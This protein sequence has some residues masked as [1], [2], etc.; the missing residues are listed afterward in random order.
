[1]MFLWI[2]RP[3]LDDAIVER[4]TTECLPP[5]RL[6]EPCSRSKSYS[7][8]S[9]IAHAQ[10]T[11]QDWPKRTRCRSELPPG[12]HRIGAYNLSRQARSG[13]WKIGRK[14]QFAP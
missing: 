5:V 12:V 4:K 1:M 10:V 11:W 8:S 9:A 7:D 13:G 14:G 2:P 6:T 3:I